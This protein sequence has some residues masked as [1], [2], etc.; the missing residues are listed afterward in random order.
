MQK[1]FLTSVSSD[2]L[3]NRTQGSTNSGCLDTTDLEGTRKEGLEFA[4][5]HTVLLT[6]AFTRHPGSM[7]AIGSTVPYEEAYLTELVFLLHSFYDLPLLL[8]GG[9]PELGAHGDFVG[10]TD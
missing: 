2:P 4:G 1:L 10:E 8:V 7:H 6:A 9:V 5:I 3:S